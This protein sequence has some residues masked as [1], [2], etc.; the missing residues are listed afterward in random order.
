M[1]GRVGGCLSFET[2][3]LFRNLESILLEN[4]AE[5]FYFASRCFLNTQKL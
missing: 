2:R 3:Q 1:L 4:T 5:S